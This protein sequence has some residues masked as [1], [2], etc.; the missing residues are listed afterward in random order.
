MA[1]PL[2]ACSL[3]LQRASRLHIAGVRMLRCRDGERKSVNRK[4]RLMPEAT[5]RRLCR[6]TIRVAA[7]RRQS[8]KWCKAETAILICLG[9]CGSVRLHHAIKAETMEER[10]KHP[11]T[12]INEPGYVSSGGSVLGCVIRNISPEGAAIDVPNP[13]FVPQRFHL[14]MAKDSSVR[15]CSIA[16]IQKNRIGVS[17]VAAP[18]AL[19]LPTRDDELIADAA[20]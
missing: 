9:I 4:S 15:E 20:G 17:F 16:W 6:P 5:H 12:E 7:R 3:F 1:F 19:R 18:Q 14:V 11:R 2:G 8:A 10:R 13:A